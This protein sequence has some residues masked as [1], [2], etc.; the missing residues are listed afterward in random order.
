MASLHTRSILDRPNHNRLVQEFFSRFRI[1]QSPIQFIGILGVVCYEFLE[2]GNILFP[3]AEPDS[4]VAE[5]ELVESL[6]GGEVMSL[7]LFQISAFFEL[8]P[9][10]RGEKRSLAFGQRVVAKVACM[11]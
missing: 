3:F 11:A 6:Q 9:I 5:G 1:Q 8:L 4:G 10:F 2:C 7:P